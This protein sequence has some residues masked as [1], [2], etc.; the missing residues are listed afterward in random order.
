MKTMTGEQLRILQSL[1]R[2]PAVRDVSAT[3][4]ISY[5]IAFKRAAV[6]D[7]RSGGSPTK[8][9]RRHGLD[10][11]I[12][13]G[14]RVERC[15]ARWSRNPAL[16]AGNDGQTEPR[17]SDGTRPAAECA[18]TAGIRGDVDDLTAIIVSMSG[19]IN[20]LERRIHTLEYKTAER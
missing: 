17:R 14:K 16:C 4:R 3:G 13:G 9:F 15:I 5:E 1:K 6:Q 10:T 12:I 11:S 8:F 20:S 2:L 19:R 7:Y 18:R